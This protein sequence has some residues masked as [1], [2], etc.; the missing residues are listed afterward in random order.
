MS[1]LRWKTN[2]I[3]TTKWSKVTQPGSTELLLHYY[4]L[5][6]YTYYFDLKY[7]ISSMHASSFSP[8]VHCSV[9]IK[10]SVNK[11][12][13]AMWETQV[14]SLGQE[15]PL[16]KEM[17]T[18]SSTLTWK[19]PW[20]KEPGRLQPVGSPRVGHDWATSLQFTSL[21][22]HQRKEGEGT[23][24]NP[25]PLSAVLIFKK[26]WMEIT[27]QINHQFSRTTILKKVK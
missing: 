22:T 17:A 18:H 25:Y 2:L 11:S 12:L 27:L 4:Y 23:D 3:K 21:Q 9:F 19:I 13:P 15:D 26:L 24:Q 14:W 6:Y 10:C 16:E 7:N 8:G 1:H 20:M 5:H